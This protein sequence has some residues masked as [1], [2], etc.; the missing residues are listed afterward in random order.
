MGF[1][2][3]SAYPW[4][5][6]GIFGAFHLVLTF[7]PFAVLGMGGGFLT[8]GMISAVL[9]GF[10]LGPFYGTLAV[11]MGSF[12]GTG[13]F[14]LGGILG[15]IVPVLAPAAG[16]FAAGA[17][18]TGRIKELF[19]LFLIA[20]VGFI[21]GPIG[22]P[23]FLFIWMHLI[24]LGII[25]ILLVPTLMNTLKN[26]VTFEKGRNLKLMPVAIFLFS[27]IALLTD[28]IVGNTVTVFYFHYILAMDA[29]TLVGFWLPITFVYPVERLLATVILSL[30]VIAAEEAIVQTGL[31]LPLS[32]WDTRE[33]LEITP[34]EV[35]NG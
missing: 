6:T 19:V 5:L 23:A 8:W 14:N 32:P 7:I 16:A 21:V 27:F 20:T 29:P 22:I 28:H 4:A 15:P 26:A 2:R 35:E 25:A 18:R 3:S 30:I 17:L 31:E 10:L 13:V 12:I 33:Q 1:T 24:T 9:V 11:L 34:E